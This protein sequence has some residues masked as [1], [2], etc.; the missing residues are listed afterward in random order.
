MLSGVEGDIGI[1][2]I[3]GERK[4]GPEYQAGIM[5]QGASPKEVWG[6]LGARQCSALIGV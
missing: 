3:S 4:V 1:W 2:R 5:P 6:A